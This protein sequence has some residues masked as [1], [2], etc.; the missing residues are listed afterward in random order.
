M[1]SEAVINDQNGVLNDQKSNPPSR[2][3]KFLIG[4]AT[5]GYPNGL[6]EKRFGKNV[7][8]KLKN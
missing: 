6:I 8:N 3:S 4:S 5:A 1:K 7:L 2:A